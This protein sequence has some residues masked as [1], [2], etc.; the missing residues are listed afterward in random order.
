[1][2]LQPGGI[3]LNLT[4]TESFDLFAPR[5]ALKTNWNGPV[6]DGIRKFS[7]SSDRLRTEGRKIL[8]N[9][10]RAWPYAA[11]RRS[12]ATVPCVENA[13]QCFG[14]ILC[15]A[16]CCV[17]FVQEKRWLLGVNLAS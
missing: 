13:S 9:Y 7:N 2:R 14:L 17:A 16:K 4:T 1:L 10:I 15:T 6:C 3:A 5:R 12:T 8:A 11:G